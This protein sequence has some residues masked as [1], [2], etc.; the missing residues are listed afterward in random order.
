MRPLRLLAPLLLCSAC[1][2]LPSLVNT[3]PQITLKSPERLTFS[4]QGVF[5]PTFTVGGYVI[6]HVKTADSTRES[7]AGTGHKAWMCAIKNPSA[8][9]SMTLAP[10]YN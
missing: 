3:A 8:L 7:G 1:S 4:Q 2:A 6:D 10:E 9:C 5:N